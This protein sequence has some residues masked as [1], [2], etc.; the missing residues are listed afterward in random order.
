VSEEAA[1]YLWRCTRHKKPLCKKK[2][3][4]MTC[5][6]EHCN[7]V[8]DSV[9]Q[10][11]NQRIHFEL[12]VEYRKYAIAT[13]MPIDPPTTRTEEGAVV[14]MPIKPTMTRT[15]DGDILE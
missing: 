13:E 11:G 15:E 14:E 9:L 5:F 6:P 2:Q 4:E 3:R 12:P 7:H 10:C 1:E 8:G